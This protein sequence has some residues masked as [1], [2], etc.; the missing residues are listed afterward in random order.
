M[1][2]KTN[3]LN[4]KLGTTAVKAFVAIN[5]FKSK[6]ITKKQLCKLSKTWLRYSKR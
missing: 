2:F 4:L 3:L 5:C 1:K 6:R